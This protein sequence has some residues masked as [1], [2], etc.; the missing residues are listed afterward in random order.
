MN[1]NSTIKV[2]NLDIKIIRINNIEY[3]SLTDLARYADKNEP[4]LPIRDWM[5]NKEVISYLGL[6]ENINNPNFN[7]GEFAPFKN[8]AG[9]NTF[10]MSPS[11]WIKNT[12]AIGIISKSGRYDSGTFAH[13][14]IA[15]EFAS[16]LSPEFKLYLIQEFQRLKKNEAYQNK[17]EWSA[18]RTLAK[19]N[20]LIHTD[21]IKNYIV[22]TLTDK[23]LH[24]V[25]AEEADVIN[26]AL[27]GMTAKEWRDNNPD[28]AKTGN[29]RDYTDLIHLII[30]NNLE[31]TNSVLI[32]DNISQKERLIRL[33]ESARN[34]MNLLCN[35]K[36]IDLLAYKD[37]Y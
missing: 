32:K 15:F 17:I 10:K 11:K 3:I 36:N 1:I 6:W 9:S 24:F 20:Y 18:N 27:F 21:A 25:Y 13:P 31:I 16:W 34:Q 35:N 22:P 4:R 30:L 14:D 2:N 5:R 12:N 26:V 33:N 37:N 23:Q 28:L 8:E 7:R 29:I 19:V